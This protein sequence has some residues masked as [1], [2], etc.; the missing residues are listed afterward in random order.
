MKTIFMFYSPTDPTQH[1]ATVS[2]ETRSLPS[3]LLPW[4]IHCSAYKILLLLFSFTKEITAN[5]LI[6]AVQLYT[7]GETQ[8]I[9]WQRSY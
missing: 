6:H 1:L 9:V 5:L 8:N 4:S 2:L 7:T 3:I